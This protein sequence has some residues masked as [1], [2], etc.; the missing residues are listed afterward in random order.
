[1]KKGS[2]IGDDST[3]GMLTVSEVAE[4]LH[5]HP[6]TVRQWSDKGVLRVFRFGSRRDRRYR[7][8]EIERFIRSSQY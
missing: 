8:E 7:R 2:R 6:N 4:L 5:M 1:M 3:N